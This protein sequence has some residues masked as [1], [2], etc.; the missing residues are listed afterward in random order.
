MKIGRATFLRSE[1][2]SVI[3]E[4]PYC[5]NVRSEYGKIVCAATVIRFPLEFH[6]DG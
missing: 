4:E 3:P 6:F 1:L 2:D 5:Y